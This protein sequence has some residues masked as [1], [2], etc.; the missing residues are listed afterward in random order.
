MLPSVATP[1]SIL[2]GEPVL[3]E[4]DGLWVGFTGRDIYWYEY[5]LC[6]SRRVQYLCLLVPVRH[7]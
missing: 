3:Y 1:S 5:L 4:M 2:D 6:N 7:L